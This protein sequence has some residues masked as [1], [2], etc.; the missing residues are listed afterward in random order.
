MLKTLEPPKDIE[1]LGND[2]LKVSSLLKEPFVATS[3]SGLR[4]VY[5]INLFLRWV[6][7]AFFITLYVRPGSLEAIFDHLKPKCKKILS[8]SKNF[9]PRQDINKITHTCFNALVKFSDGFFFLHAEIATF[10]IRSEVINPL[11][12]TTLVSC[13]TS[14]ILHCNCNCMHI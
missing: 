13:H 2:S 11:K 4:L 8:E 9:E 1:A 5:E 12:A 7:H 10:H 14:T 3:S 6:Y